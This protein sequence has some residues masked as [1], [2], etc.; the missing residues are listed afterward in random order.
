MDLDKLSRNLGIKNTSKRVFELLLGSKPSPVADIAKELMLPKSTV[1]DAISELMSKSLLVEYSENDAKSYGIASKE[2]IVKLHQ[3][4]IEELKLS[5]EFISKKLNEV[6]RQSILQPKIKFYFGKDGMKHAFNDM[7][8]VEGVKE[9]YLM[10]PMKKMI[11]LVGE[12]FLIRHGLNRK[13]Y[14]IKI[15]AISKESD[16]KIRK[17]G[18]N[19]ETGSKNFREV[20]YAPQNIDWSIS[21]WVYDD[22]TMFSG[23]DREQFAFIVYSKE[24][25]ELMKTL[26]KQVWNV[27]KD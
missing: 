9:S 8:W 23:G 1:Y 14:K 19:W 4:K 10:W 13:K 21:Y 11:D 22:K 27:S 18:G 25:A 26:W 15:K 17:S 2:Q 5:Q 24:F 6:S 12:E 7:P 16:R 20:R 3:E